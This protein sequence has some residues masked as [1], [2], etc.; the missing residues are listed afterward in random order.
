MWSVAGL[1]CLV[2]SPLF[3]IFASQFTTTALMCQRPKPQLETCQLGKTNIFLFNTK[4]IPIKKLQGARIYKQSISDSTGQFQTLV[5]ITNEKEIVFSSTKTFRPSITSHELD[6]IAYQINHFVNNPQE[7]SL[8]I[9][10]G[11]ILII[12]IFMAVITLNLLWF[13][14]C[15]DVVTCVFDKSRGSLIKKRQ[16]FLIITKTVEYQLQDIIDIQVQ[17]KQSRSFTG[18]RI[19]LFRDSGKDIHLT[20]YQINYFKDRQKMDETADA[21]A[22]FLSR[23]SNSRFDS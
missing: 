4:N 19:T 16:W 2:W 22:K 17:E 23:Y 3:S 6:K 10:K 12:K 5:L 20:T 13:A 18:Y 11:D 8:K 21:I 1:C 9:E 15:S 14:F 7:S